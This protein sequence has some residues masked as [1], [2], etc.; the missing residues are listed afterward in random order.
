MASWRPREDPRGATLDDQIMRTIASGLPSTPI[1]SPGANS[2]LPLDESLIADRRASVPFERRRVVRRVGAGAR[3]D[4]RE[5]GLGD[6]AQV[7]LLSLIH[8]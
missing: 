3:G 5:L 1:S 6:D 7:H 2:R 4:A 8:I